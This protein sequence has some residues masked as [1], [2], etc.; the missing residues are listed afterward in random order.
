MK[1]LFIL[2]MAILL[3]IFLTACSEAISFDNIETQIIAYVSSIIAVSTTVLSIVD[4]FK[5]KKL[6]EKNEKYLNI[7]EIH[8]YADRCIIELESDP[9]LKHKGNR[10]KELVIA[11]CI[12]Q[13]PDLDVDE[14]SDYIDDKIAFT[15]VVNYD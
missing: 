10:K 1:K 15:K 3:A 6:K 12:Q 11:K 4:A 5:K 9:D 13:Y 8:E 14:L 7:V 2:H